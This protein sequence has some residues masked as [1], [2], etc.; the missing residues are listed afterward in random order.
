MENPELKPST[1]V[2][3]RSSLHAFITGPSPEAPKTKSQF[4]PYRRKPGILA[5]LGLEEIDELIKDSSLPPNSS[6]EEKNTD[7]SGI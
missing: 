5:F 1:R 2:L 6:E 3:S 7:I 4:N